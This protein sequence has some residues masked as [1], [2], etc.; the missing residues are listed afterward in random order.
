MN[1]SYVAKRF[2]ALLR[3]T[4]RAEFSN[5][6][7]RRNG[8]FTFFSGFSFLLLGG[9]NNSI[10]SFP[11]KREST[12]RVTLWIPAFAGM[13]IFRTTLKYQIN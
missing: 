12:P 11:R 13:T 1:K 6:P 5:N 4:I 3:M 8:K 9:S 10:L 2:F 7:I